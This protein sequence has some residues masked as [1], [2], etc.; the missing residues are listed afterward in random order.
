[1]KRAIDSLYLTNRAFYAG[2]GLVVLFL[3]AQAFP[4]LLGI[5]RAAFTLLLFALLAD[6]FVLYRIREGIRAKRTTWE[7]WSNGDENP[8][9]ITVE[10]RYPI[11]VMVRVIDELPEQFQRRD[12]SF[13]RMLAAGAT[14]QLPYAVRP[15][16][17]G[18]YR[19]GAINVFVRTMLGLVE[20][21]YSCEA[22][23]E[24]AV[25]PSYIHLRRYELMAIS[26]R[27]VMAGRK[28]V[29]RIAQQ[30]EFDRIKEYVAGD[31]RRTV[32]QKATA[33]RGRLM[34]NQYQDEKAQQ[35][36]ALIDAGRT[37]KMPFQGMSLLD[38]AINA[39]L[40]ISD[41]AMR[42]DDRAGLIVFSDRVHAHV[43]AARERG[44]MNK[45]LEVLYGLRTDHA[46]SDLEHL[47]VG[48]K[49]T[50][51][52][53][54]LLLLFTNF[55]SVNGL[56]RQL[57]RIQALAATHL[58]VVIFFLNTT[59]EEDLRKPVSD[60]AEVY[61]RT[62]TERYLHEKRQVVVELERRGIASILSRPEDLSINVINKYLEIKARSRL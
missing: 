40:A 3:L 32:N 30:V 43:A 62:I 59:L 54:S 44:H 25:Y 14:E 45:V 20:R 39:A 26:D 15:V 56:Q 31:D 35:V 41:V 49:R 4:V 18:V 2:W 38:Y 8:V 47:Y 60:T 24:V 37:M 58:V 33:R 36:Y 21:R 16:V 12:L 61:T 48:V 1:M 10:N 7:K 13:S 17:R 5:A 53:R 46:E 57:P 55:E 42:K 23:R 22:E 19:Y 28:K 27:L 51:P 52:Q 6:L 11:K 29:R 9:T 34:V 50:I